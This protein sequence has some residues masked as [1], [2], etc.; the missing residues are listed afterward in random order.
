[1]PLQWLRLAALADAPTRMLARC[2]N[3]APSRLP[4][5]L[6]LSL[7]EAVLSRPPMPRRS[8]HRAPSTLAR[9]S[10]RARRPQIQGPRAVGRGPAS[11]LPSGR[12]SKPGLRAGAPRLVATRTALG[13][14]WGVGRG[15]GQR[16]GGGQRVRRLGCARWGGRGEERALVKTQRWRDL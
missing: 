6:S 2:V 11:W 4:C 10:S 13:R 1:M 14:L 9:P 15:K 7:S 12:V 8:N 16:R 3:D 5:E